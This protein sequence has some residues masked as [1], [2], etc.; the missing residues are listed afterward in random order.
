MPLAGWQMH[1]NSPDIL[2]NYRLLSGQLA[3]TASS[4][5]KVNT[6]TVPTTDSTTAGSQRCSQG[7]RSQY[8]R[9][10]PQGQTLAIDAIG[11]FFGWT[12]GNIRQQV[13]TYH[14]HVT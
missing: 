9:L 13:R 1:K 10:D 3:Q 14:S 11:K 6:S 5:G 7:Y 4:C 8:Q 2:Q 12:E